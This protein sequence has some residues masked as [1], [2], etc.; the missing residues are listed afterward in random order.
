MTE[1]KDHGFQLSNQL[2]F[3]IIGVMG[4]FLL[5]IG[6]VMMNNM[7]SINTSM[8]VVRTELKLSRESNDARLAALERDVKELREAQAAEEALRK[9]GIQR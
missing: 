5:T 7:M 9:A 8:A 3:W 4:T 1:D 2:V 6:G